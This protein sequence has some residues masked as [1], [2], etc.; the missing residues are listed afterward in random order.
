M[1]NLFVNFN[2]LKYIDSHCYRLLHYINFSKLVIVFLYPASESIVIIKCCCCLAN[3]V[4]PS[5]KLH[6]K[7]HLFFCC[8]F[9]LICFFITNFIFFCRSN[10]LIL[11][12]FLPL[13]SMAKYLQNHSSPNNLLCVLCFEI[14]NSLVRIRIICKKI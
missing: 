8:P 1:N 3:F 4:R 12:S 7:F 11:S 9:E 13:L 6:Y 10:N 14:I 2:Y 5:Q